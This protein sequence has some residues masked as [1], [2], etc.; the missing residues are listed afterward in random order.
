MLTLLNLHQPVAFGTLTRRYKRFLAD[1]VLESGEQVTA[2]CPNPGRMLTCSEPGSQVRLSYF[3][4]SSRKYP[5]QLDLVKSGDVWVGVN[6]N[7]ANEIVDLAIHQGHIF[8]DLDSEQW[9]RE[10][11]YGNASRIDFLNYGTP[12]IY[13]EVKSV[14]YA[15]SGIG[16]FPDAV[17]V[18]ATKHLDELSNVVSAGHRGIVI[19]CIQ[20]DDILGE[21]K[22]A[23]H[24]DPSYAKAFDRAKANGVEFMTLPIQFDSAGSRV[25]LNLNKVSLL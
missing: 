14:S 2:Y 20:R 12:N 3:E 18:R 6:P 13:V 15:L 8:E 4:T 24:I 9:K 11:P 21:V 10:V 5:Y 16:Y 17:S 22:P 23:T 19:F 25:Y 1:V 7:L